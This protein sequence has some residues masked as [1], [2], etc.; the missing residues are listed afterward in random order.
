M[1]EAQENLGKIIGKITYLNPDVMKKLMNM[2]YKDDEIDYECLIPDKE[3]NM[4][5]VLA[6]SEIVYTSN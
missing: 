5:P 4:T 2:R 3:G 6:K 1:D